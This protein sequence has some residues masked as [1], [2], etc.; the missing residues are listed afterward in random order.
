MENKT[1]KKGKVVNALWAIISKFLSGIKLVIL[2][3]I[4]ARYLGPDQFG[5]YSYTVSFVMLLA[6]LAEFRLHNIL[7]REISK[8]KINTETI[9][10]S[11][12]FTCFFFSLIGYLTL[13]VLVR[14]IEDN[15]RLRFSILIYGLTY[16]FQT[17]R[18]L[19]AFF[20]AKY[21]NAVIFKIETIVSIVILTSAILISKYKISVLSFIILR[22]FDIVLLSTML[23]VFYQLRNKKIKKWNFDFKISKQIII[24]SSPLVISSL[25][26]VIFQQFDQIMIKHILNEYSVGQYSAAVSIISLIVFIPVVLTEVITPSLVNLRLSEEEESYNNR[27]QLFSDYILWSSVLICVLVTL[28]SPIIVSFIYGKEYVE[29]IAIL[30]IFAWQSVLIAMGSVAAQIMIIDNKHQ[31]AYMKSISGGIL[32]IILN[33][34]FI[35]KYGIM[36]AVWASLIAYAIS[37]YIAHFF[38]KRY[39]YIFLIQTRSLIYG[40]RNIFNDLK[41]I[42]K[43]N[44]D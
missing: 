41:T 39:K 3:V 11:A 37:S 14:I 20:I 12:F 18:F 16:F 30:K 7:I 17:L 23:V 4:V 35:P 32:N 19:R 28:L 24:S 8:N 43:K 42:D 44:Y 22:I 9:L 31:I 5:A 13:F 36:G 21:Q 34:I 2:G 33:F 29:S 1:F 25:A 15:I 40:L 38:I 10:G 26:L 27:L 6:V